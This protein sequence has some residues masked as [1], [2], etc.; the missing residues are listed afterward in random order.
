MQHGLAED[1]NR[2]Q[3]LFF[4]LI[5]GIGLTIMA[6]DD[7]DEHIISPLRSCTIERAENSTVCSLFSGSGVGAGR[8]PI[9]AMTHS[10]KPIIPMRANA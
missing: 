1:G 6:D 10:W 7:D 8:R 5:S 3:T 9:P 4:Q 2:V